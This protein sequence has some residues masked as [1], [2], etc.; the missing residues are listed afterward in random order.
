[1]SAPTWAKWVGLGALALGGVGIAALAMQNDD[2]GGTTP[3]NEIEGDDDLDDED[4]LKVEP[5][6]VPDVFKR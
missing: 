3:P 6:T 1:M 2:E 4:E 5:E